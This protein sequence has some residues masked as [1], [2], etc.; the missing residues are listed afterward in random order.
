LRLL[1]SLPAC[2][3]GEA[4]TF[5]G[6]QDPVLCS[7]GV[8][9]RLVSGYSFSPPAPPTLSRVSWIKWCARARRRRRARM[10]F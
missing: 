6:G 4:S 9:G 1:L 3:G 7:R 10:S 5:A 2:G 8:M